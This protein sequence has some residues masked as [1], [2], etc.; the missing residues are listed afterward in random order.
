M[1]GIK[2]KIQR[3]LSKKLVKREAL[4][5]P[6]STRNL[7]L[8]KKPR[9]NQEEVVSLLVRGLPTGQARHST[10]TIKGTTRF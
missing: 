4:D 8:K 7:K 5:D 9:K 6:K 3:N 1:E 2:G 10:K